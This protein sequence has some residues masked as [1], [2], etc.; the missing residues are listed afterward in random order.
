[1]CSP[2]FVVSFFFSGFSTDHC[3]PFGAYVRCVRCYMTR[4]IRSILF[5]KNTTPSVVFTKRV[6]PPH[7]RKKKSVV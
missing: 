7:T 5:Y 6:P 3:V 2:S 1:M 4:V